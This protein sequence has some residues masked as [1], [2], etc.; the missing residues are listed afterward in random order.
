MGD[1]CDLLAYLQHERKVPRPKLIQSTTQGHDPPDTINVD[2]GTR[3]L[4]PDLLLVDERDDNG[5]GG[6]GQRVF[7]LQPGVDV[8]ERLRKVV[9]CLW[10]VG[11]W[12]EEDLVA[13]LHKSKATPESYPRTC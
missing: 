6:V 11:T 12:A 5:Q 1:T 7:A 10:R 9:K 3:V 8:E 13:C 4:I 2:S